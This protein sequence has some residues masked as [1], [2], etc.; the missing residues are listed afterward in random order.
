MDI[1]GVLTNGKV[2][3]DENGREFKTLDYRDID[4]V[5]ALK[6]AG[7]KIGLI[8]GEN[9]IITQVFKKKFEP[10]FFYNGCKNKAKAVNEIINFLCLNYEEVCYI[11]DGFYDI[12][13]MKLAG[14]SIC[15]NNAIKEVKAISTVCL[16]SNGG[17]GCIKELY[18]YI[19]SL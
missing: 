14:L 9:S 19:I 4:A 15:P 6:R 18:D 13:A 10:D 11:G 17:D 7:F 5:F 8:S 3:I 2:S 1:D 12:E 16:T